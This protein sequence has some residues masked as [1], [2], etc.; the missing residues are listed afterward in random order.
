VLESLAAF[1]RRPGSGSVL[2]LVTG[3][4]VPPPP[5]GGGTMHLLGLPTLCPLRALTGV[6][7]P[8]CGMTRALCLCCHGRFFEA[9]TVYHPAVP[10]VLVG[11][12]AAAVYGLAAR[13]PL[14]ERWVAVYAGIMVALL[15]G[16]W[17]ARLFHALPMP[18]P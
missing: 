12:I 17:L 6:P 16:I 15:L 18:P 8:G 7:C 11:L 9:V 5:V 1:A 4:V 14:P 2:V 3:F 10:L 13:K